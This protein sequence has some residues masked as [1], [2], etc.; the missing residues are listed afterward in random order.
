M[1]ALGFGREGEREARERVLGHKH[2]A[3]HSPCR[4]LGECVLSRSC[5]RTSESGA[6]QLGPPNATATANG[7][8]PYSGRD[9]VKSLHSGRDCVKPLWPS[10]TGLY[11]QSCD[12]SLRP[13]PTCLSSIPRT[14]CTVHFVRGMMGPAGVA[15]VFCDIQ[16]NFHFCCR[17]KSFPPGNVVRASLQFVVSLLGTETFS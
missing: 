5:S 13:K 4:V 15:D 11:S 17:Q 1:M 12:G 3:S 8:G 16:V 6:R 10:Y 7:G 9:C 14:K 2:R